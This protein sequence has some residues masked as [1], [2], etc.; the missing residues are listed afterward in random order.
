MCAF[1][2]EDEHQDISLVFLLFYLSDVCSRV[3]VCSYHTFKICA[4]SHKKAE[5]TKNKR[6]NC[7]FE[8]QKEFD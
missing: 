6:S 4:S 5:K 7:I 2:V 1:I 3:C 8:V